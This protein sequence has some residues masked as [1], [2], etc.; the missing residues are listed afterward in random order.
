MDIETATPETGPV[1]VDA[2]IDS[3]IADIGTD[4]TQTDDIDE[5]LSEV[6]NETENEGQ[7]ETD[8]EDEGAEA[9]PEVEAEE[10]EV[11][12]PQTY[13]VKVNGEELDVPLDEL[14]NGYSRTQDYKTKT[15]EVAEQRRAVE[16]ER[17]GMASEYV[18]EL[19]RATDLFEATDPV[20]SEARQTNWQQLAQENPTYYGQLRA[21]VDERVALIAAKRDEMG[22]IQSAVSEHEAAQA[23]EATKTEMELLFAAMPELREPEKQAA[24]SKETNEYLAN[25]GFSE[26]DIAEIG[27]H[28]AFMIVDKARRW[29]AHQK[30]VAS[31]PAKKVVSVSDVKALKTDGSSQAPQNRLKPG[32]S[33]DAKLDWALRELSE[34]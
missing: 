14:L 31:L 15:A 27:D 24:F 6:A 34:G 20:L 22:R 32:A 7:P 2:S 4:I 29:D 17:V 28:R 25:V 30:A 11:E 21:A 8:P 1:S 26:D 33:R 19:K 13:K 5:I 16:A 18:S 9:E 12:A 23:A 10:S 3:I